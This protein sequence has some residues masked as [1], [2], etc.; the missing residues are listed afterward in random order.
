MGPAEQAALQVTGTRE[1]GST[2][3]YEASG[4]GMVLSQL[5]IARPCFLRRHTLTPAPAPVAP[6]KPTGPA[7]G[8]SGPA[9]TI[10]TTQ[11]VIGSPAAPGD[12]QEPAGKEIWAWA[13]NQG[14]D[15]EP[16]SRGN[17]CEKCTRSQAQERECGQELSLMYQST[18]HSDVFPWGAG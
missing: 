11:T 17:G 2:D 14:L 16:G 15:R 6:L 3:T 1:P 4:V 8:L 5:L 7:A 18:S 13:W 12:F 9:G 10:R